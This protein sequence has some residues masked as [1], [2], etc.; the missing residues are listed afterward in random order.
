MSCAA[1]IGLIGREPIGPA[2]RFAPVLRRGSLIARIHSLWDG[3]SYSFVCRY[4]LA[5]LV[6]EINAMDGVPPKLNS[7]PSPAWHTTTAD[8]VLCYAVVFVL[9]G[10]SRGESSLFS[11]ALAPFLIHDAAFAFWICHARVQYFVRYVEG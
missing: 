1:L 11:T 10:V 2:L 9:P 3:G 6:C 4:L 5:P 7:S 8:C